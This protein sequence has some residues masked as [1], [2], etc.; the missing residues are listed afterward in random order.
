[1]IDTRTPPV[2]LP[3]SFDFETAEDGDRVETDDGREFVVLV[4]SYSNDRRIVH[5]DVVDYGLATHPAVTGVLGLLTIIAVI[6]APG[7]AAVATVGSASATFGTA[8]SP[9]ITIAVTVVALLG[10]VVLAN[11]VLYRTVFGD[12][13][14]RFLEFD[15]AKLQILGSKS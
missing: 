8:V 10:G 7:V 5:A 2:G 1:M 14:F 6:L 3:D 4:N 13:V 9:V 11:Q 12:W 15:D